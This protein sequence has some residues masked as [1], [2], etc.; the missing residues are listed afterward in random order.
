MSERG[1]SDIDFKNKI[2]SGMEAKQGW[3]NRIPAGVD[4]FAPTQGKEMISTSG[5]PLKLHSDV[6][7][8]LVMDNVTFDELNYPSQEEFLSLHSE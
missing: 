7:T 8:K 2:D 4:F 3:P 5:L 6:I 1:G